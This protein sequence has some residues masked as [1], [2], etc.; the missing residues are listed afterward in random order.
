[1]AFFESMEEE[2]LSNLEFLLK[3][4]CCVCLYGVSEKKKKEREMKGIGVIRQGPLLLKGERLKDSL[5]IRGINMLHKVTK[6][7]DETRRGEEK[8]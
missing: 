3:P 8:D 2:W 4:D 1:M 6:K 7:S 5:E